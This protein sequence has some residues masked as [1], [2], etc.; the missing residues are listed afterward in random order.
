MSNSQPIFRYN[1]HRQVLVEQARMNKPNSWS[2][3]TRHTASDL[4][5]AAKGKEWID[6]EN[7]L[8]SLREYPVAPGDW[9]E[10]VDYVEG[11]QFEIRK[12]YIEPPPHIHCNRGH[13]VY[14]AFLITNSKKEIMRSELA[15]FLDQ[16]Q[17]LADADNIVIAA[18][19]IDVLEFYFLS[20]DTPEQAYTNYKTRFLPRWNVLTDHGTKTQA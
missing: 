4:G 13:D 20:G 2:Y 17:H 11:K 7:H 6:Y 15:E 14:T 12:V 16:M 5:F 8:A 10:D 3:K 19:H 9:K 1:A 18:R